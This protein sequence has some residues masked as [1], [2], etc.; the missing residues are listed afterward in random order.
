MAWTVPWN[1]IG[2]EVSGD[3]DGLTIYTNRFGKKVAFPKA[4]PKEPPSAR[5]II[6]RA[7][8]K[9]AQAAWMNLSGTQK[10]SLEDATKK[11]SA[12]LTGQNLYISS[13]IRNSNSDLIT[14]ESQSGI[15]LPRIP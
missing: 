11:V 3:I 1:L 8:F 2:M 14:F 7:A 6:Q 4:P 13:I 5:Q 15:T 10:T 9:T 12:P